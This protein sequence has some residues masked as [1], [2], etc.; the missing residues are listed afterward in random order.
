[1]GLLSLKSANPTRRRDIKSKRP[2]SALAVELPLQIA[3]DGL[4]TGLEMGFWE[5][6]G[7]VPLP[8]RALVRL[9]EGQ[10]A[11]ERLGLAPSP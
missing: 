1:M 11:R 9:H 8:A 3:G 7:V 10:G 6:G 4:A 2:P 5:V